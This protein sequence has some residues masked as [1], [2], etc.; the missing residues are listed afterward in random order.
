MQNHNPT[1][2]DPLCFLY[3]F[4]FKKDKKYQHVRIPE[5]VVYEHGFAR[6][7]YYYEGS[8]LYRHS[9]KEVADNKLIYNTFKRS[10]DRRKDAVV[11]IYITYAD[12]S[13]QQNPLTSLLRDKE[14]RAYNADRR[15]LWTDV[16]IPATVTA[17]STMETVSVFGVGDEKFTIQFFTREQLKSFI[18]ERPKGERGV[19]QRFIRSRLPRNEIIK[20]VWTPYLCMV[21]R[22]QN[23][24]R[25]ADPQ[26]A[27]YERSV[28]EK[29]HVNHVEEGQIAPTQAERV[30]Q[31]CCRLVEDLRAMEGPARSVTQMVVFFKFDRQCQLHIVFCPVIEYHT[32]PLRA[33][34]CPPSAHSVMEPLPLSPP[35]SQAAA[36]DRDRS[37]DE[38]ALLARMGKLES[39]TTAS[40]PVQYQFFKSVFIANGSHGSAL[41]NS[42]VPALSAD[43]GITPKQSLLLQRFEKLV[44]DVEAAKHGFAPPSTL[45]ASGS[46][47]RLPRT[48]SLSVAAPPL[49]P[50]PFQPAVR[51][52]VT[53]AGQGG[54]SPSASGI[55]TAGGDQSDGAVALAGV[56][57]APGHPQRIRGAVRESRESQ[58]Q[59]ET[60]ARHTLDTLSGCIGSGS[61][62]S[63]V[64]AP[65]MGRI[66]TPSESPGSAAVQDERSPAAANRRRRLPTVGFHPLPLHGVGN[67]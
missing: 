49:A 38:V 10:T 5:T 14:N 30:R 1:L 15:G 11:A 20:A 47:A 6:V 53:G 8:T 3:N 50:S 44:A 12:P 18:N 16:Y 51:F 4:I 33:V 52:P 21:H 9:P 64:P 23:V 54:S 40:L 59:R 22:R 39:I 62:S 43:K 26:Y 63:A 7:W 34:L 46:A 67:G 55:G 42:S 13:T 2:D 61:P 32:R 65:C 19:L 36:A 31:F 66:S 45:S 37:H 58:V 24:H 28:T 29:M 17:A 57:D 60:M 48:R 25:Y 27:L 41:M 56:P 35:H